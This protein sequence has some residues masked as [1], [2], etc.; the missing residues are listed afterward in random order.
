MDEVA[1]YLELAERWK[2]A[3]RQVKNHALGACYAQR[4]ARYLALASQ[5]QSQPQR[6]ETL[7]SKAAS[8]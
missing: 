7:S 4:A 1:L 8:S 2:A 3:A 6:N 5:E